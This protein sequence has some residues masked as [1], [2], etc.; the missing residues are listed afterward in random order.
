[1]EPVFVNSGSGASVRLGLSAA[2]DIVTRHGGD[3]KI[4]KWE[5]APDQ[6]MG[7]GPV[8]DARAEGGVEHAHGMT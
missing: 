2:H 1:M 8:I 4:V 7:V 6:E 3:L 5:G